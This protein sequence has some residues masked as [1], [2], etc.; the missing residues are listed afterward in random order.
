MSI[1]IWGP[2]LFSSDSFG[3]SIPGTYS[4]LT[5]SLNILYSKDFIRSNGG[6]VISPERLYAIQQESVLSDYCTC[7]RQSNRKAHP[8]QLQVL[9]DPIE[10]S[11]GIN[12]SFLGYPVDE[13]SSTRAFPYPEACRLPFSI[14][15]SSL[16]DRKIICSIHGSS[17]FNKKLL[18]LLLIPW[19]LY[20]TV[21]SP[22]VSGLGTVL[23]CI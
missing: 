1:L 21:P 18:F 12:S 23:C 9:R 19:R 7:F 13:F 2:S 5:L 16:T 20:R 14:Y 15:C 11:P 22:A 6:D 4:V 10:K 17:P 3:L 8:F